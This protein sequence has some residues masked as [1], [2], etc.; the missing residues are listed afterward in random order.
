MG[1]CRIKKDIQFVSL[2]ITKISTIITNCDSVRPPPPPVT[3]A[4][5][6]GSALEYD[7]IATKTDTVTLSLEGF[8]LYLYAR[9]YDDVYPEN[10]T[11][12]EK[13]RLH[14]IYK[15]LGVPVPKGI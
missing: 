5:T 14:D 8:I 6:V 9:A 1:L 3:V 13:S 4:K 15:T 10:P 2:L 12:L 7:T 11:P